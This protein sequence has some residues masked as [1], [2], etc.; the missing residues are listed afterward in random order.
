M[1]TLRGAYTALVTPF[2]A[3]G[4]A[5][6]LRRL[7]DNI[8]AQA[9][10]G[11]AGVVPC[12]TTGEAPALADREHR[13]VVET[14]IEAARKLGLR[15]MAGAGSN[16][17][18]RAVQLH[19]FAHEAGA[20]SALHVTPYYNRPS[21]EGLYR[22]FAAV[23]DSCDLPVVLYNVPVRTGV[24]LAI[25]T[26]ERLAGHPNIAG[27]KEASGSLDLASA[28]AGRTDLALLSGD[29]TLTLPIAAVGGVGVVSVVGNL[30]PERMAA[31]CRA[32]LDGQWPQARHIHLETFDLARGMLSL[33]PNPAPVKAALQ[34]LERDTGALRLP[35]CP[36]DGKARE[37]VAELL[38]RA[39]LAAHELAAP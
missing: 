34:L 29:D 25:E 23:A 13:A 33:G 7:A 1:T 31:L 30:V 11:V 6:D 8:A 2:T 16:S 15:V 37:A 26:I 36:L 35:L 9:A 3:D 12:G 17:T 21:Q 28:I 18:G 20:D 10:G 4:S 24:S 39:G 22:H 14:A 5:V 19:R 27:I 32:F 38:H